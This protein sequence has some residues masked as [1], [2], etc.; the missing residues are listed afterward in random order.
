M[1][2]SNEI[3]LNRFNKEISIDARNIDRKVDEI[4]KNLDDLL[5]YLDIDKSNNNIPSEK[6]KYLDPLLAKIR[7]NIRQQETSAGVYQDV[8]RE[9]SQRSAQANVSNNKGLSGRPNMC[10]VCK[11]KL[12]KD[13]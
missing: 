12:W 1:A 9:N 4:I 2:S 13:N 11:V 3:K 8:E 5:K 7:Y 6:V 10:Y